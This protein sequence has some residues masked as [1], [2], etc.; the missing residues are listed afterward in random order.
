[1]KR[2]TW[3][4]R[5]STLETSKNREFFFVKLVAEMSDNIE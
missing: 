5:T 4:K 1:M 3:L 2:A